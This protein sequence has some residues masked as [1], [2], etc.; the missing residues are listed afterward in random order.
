MDALVYIKKYG[1][2]PETAPEGVRP[3]RITLVTNFTDDVLERVLGGMCLTEGVYPTITR[4]P[5]KQYSFALK[6]K[7]SELYVTKPDATFFFFDFSPYTHGEFGQEGHIEDVCNDLCAYCSSTTGAVIVSLPLLPYTG[8]YGHLFKEDPLYKRAVEFRTRLE[9]LTAELPNVYLFDTDKVAHHMGEKHIRDLR[10]GAA[11]DMPFTSEFCVALAHEWLSYIYALT[12]RA[13]KCI[14]LDL[15]NTLWGGVV[16]EAGPRGIALGGAYPGNAYADF[17]RALLRMWERGI[18]LAINSKN[19]ATD[20]D[21][22]FEQNPHMILTKDHFAAIRTNWDDKTDN[23]R[24]IAAELNIGLDSL[25]FL[26]D[27]PV[28]RERMRLGLPEVLTSELPAAPEEYTKLLFSLNVF[29]QMRLTREDKEKG[30]MYADE[31]KRREVEHASASLEEYIA[32]LG[33]EVTVAQGSEVDIARAAQ[34]TQKTNQLNLTTKRY[35]EGDIAA[36]I[37]RGDVVMTGEVKDKFGHYGIVILAIVTLSG[38]PALDT[39]LMSCRVMGRGV[40]KTFFDALKAELRTRGIKELQATFVPTKKNA[41][42]VGL[43]ASLG[44][45]EVSRGEGG[46]VL[47]TVAV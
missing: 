7:T 23:M 32:N 21:E 6:D 39:F 47:Y 20:V 10:G 30:K 29:H 8:A 22:V 46:E 44:A 43:L 19:N 5:Y 45:K 41:P 17:Q 27:S 25:V 26:D 3:V 37:K 18:L 34:L 35:S 36:M 40:E 42:A 33:L 13:R 15:D 4:A 28:E 2:K 16:G 9:E 31:R 24:S 11:F 38:T 1:A 14:V 12:G